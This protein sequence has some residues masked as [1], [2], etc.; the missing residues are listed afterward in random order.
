MAHSCTQ[1]QSLRF[2]SSQVMRGCQTFLNSVWLRACTH[3][4]RRLTG[5][6][7]RRLTGPIAHPPSCT[8]TVK[9]ERLVPNSTQHR[10]FPVVCLQQLLLVKFNSLHRIYS[11]S[12]TWKGTREVELLCLIAGRP[13]NIPQ[14]WHFWLAGG[15]W[16]E[17]FCV[18]LSK[19]DCW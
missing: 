18:A 15:R 14:G 17:E 3:W 9:N 5:H 12:R 19:W 6:W 13:I 7:L 8:W 4:L 16:S 2:H 11:E 1:S 10:P